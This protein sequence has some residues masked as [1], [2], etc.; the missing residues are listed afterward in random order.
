ML[1]KYRLREY[2]LADNFPFA[3]GD[4]LVEG[5]FQ[6]HSHD[7][8]ELVVI[9][10]GVG[11][12]VINGIGHPSR[13]GDLFVFHGNAVHEFQNARGLRMINVALTPSLLEPFH[14]EL[15]TL[16]GYQALFVPGQKQK[17][18]FR[19]TLH[20]DACD[21]Q[22]I[23]SILALVKH[24][25]TQKK[26][27]YRSLIIS[28]MA[29]IAVL[30]SRWYHSVK[31][32]PGESGTQVDTLAMV[33]A[34]IASNLPQKHSVDSLQRITHLSRRHF[35]RQFNLAY[36]MSPIQYVL[37]KRLEQAAIFLKE[38]HHSITDIAFE[39]GFSDSNYFTRQ[40]T[41][42]FGISPRQFRSVFSR[43]SH[44]SALNAVAS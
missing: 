10:A 23:R 25:F 14:N 29:Q 13:S 27:G 44:S 22:T 8:I 30:I 40:F 5:A 2:R 39:C 9:Y 33:A 15:M 38:S 17:G 34:H 4:A 12:H 41:A 43:G 11:T 32:T 37:Q 7:F 20:L 16:P 21:L 42:R 3:I 36:G 6:E 19:G 1:K 35:I 31:K 24:E 26:V 18:I 28:Y